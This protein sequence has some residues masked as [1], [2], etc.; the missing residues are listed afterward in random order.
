MNIKELII[1]L[2]N[3]EKNFD[4]LFETLLQKKNAIV[5]NNYVA[6]DEVIKS[7]QNIL[8]MIDSEERIRRQLIEEFASKHSL[9]LI[10]FSMDELLMSGKSNLVQEQK[11]IEKIRFNIKEKVLR[12][13]HLNSQL[14]VLIEVSR[15]MIKERMMVLL[16]NGKRKLV[17][18]RV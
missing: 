12:I 10:N 14:S 6:L 13:N 16:G 4:L 1:S 8:T 15:H 2:Q 11:N 18:K 5:S 3:Q 17:N 7:E 9:S